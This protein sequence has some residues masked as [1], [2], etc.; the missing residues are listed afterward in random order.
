VLALWGRL[1]PAER[2]AFDF[3]LRAIDW[4]VYVR[5]VHTEG[6]RRHVLRC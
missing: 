1:G 2:A 4:Y 6:L 5:D 3:D